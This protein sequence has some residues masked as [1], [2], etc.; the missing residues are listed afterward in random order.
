MPPQ[1]IFVRQYQPQRPIVIN[2]PQ[3]TV[4]FDYPAFGFSMLMVG[5]IIVYMAY[6]NPTFKAQILP[7]L[8]VFSE[9]MLILLGGCLFCWLSCD[10]VCEKMNKRE[11]NRVA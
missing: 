2:E 10:D 1:P 4:R 6:V 7:Y 11:V 3:E 8:S 9:P 5:I